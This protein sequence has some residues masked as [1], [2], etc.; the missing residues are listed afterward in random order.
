MNSGG[1]SSTGTGD[2]R[3]QSKNL[4]ANRIIG[5]APAL[6]A[7]YKGIYRFAV[8]IKAADLD[9]VRHFLRRLGYHRRT[10]VLIDIDPV[11]TV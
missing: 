1:S 11:N 10:D 2:R 8:L 7:C 3:R 9:R 6:I 5:P 4:P